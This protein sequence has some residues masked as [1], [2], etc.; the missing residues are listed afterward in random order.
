L[1]RTLAEEL[2]ATPSAGAHIAIS[3][4]FDTLGLGGRHTSPALDLAGMPH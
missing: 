4:M 3:M 1:G 2:Q